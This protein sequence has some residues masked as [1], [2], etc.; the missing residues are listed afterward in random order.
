MRELN[1]DFWGSIKFRYPN[2]L[3]GFLD[4]IFNELAGRSNIYRI[5][6]DGIWRT[7]GFVM[8]GLFTGYT[9]QHE[10]KQDWFRAKGHGSVAEQV[11][12]WFEMEF[13]RNSNFPLP[14]KSVYPTFL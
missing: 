12:R 6:R 10:H 3:E 2:E 7:P 4:Y 11:A 14:K 8:F 9:M 5:D 1:K 13:R